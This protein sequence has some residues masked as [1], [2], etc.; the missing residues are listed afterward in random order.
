MQGNLKILSNRSKLKLE[1][2]LDKHGL[3]VPFFVWHT[4]DGDFLLDGHQRKFVLVENGYSEFHVPCL[5]ITANTLD[6][7]REKLLIISSQ[8]GLITRLGL[9]TFVADMGIDVKNIINFNN[10]NLETLNNPAMEWTGMPAFEQNDA[11]SAFRVIVH[12]PDEN[13][14]LEFASKID[15]PFNTKTKF[16]WYPPHTQPN[17]QGVNRFVVTTK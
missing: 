9:D 2:S 3:F 7:A 4:A 10:L 1:K 15:V 14:L 5:L 8:Y 13:A 6:E 17:R 12:F 11:S 16:I